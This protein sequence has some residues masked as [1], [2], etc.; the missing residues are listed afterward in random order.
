MFVVGLVIWLGA[1][2]VGPAGWAVRLRTALAGGFASAGARAEEKGLDLGPVGSW[3]AR[4]H[5]A[6]QIAG[7]V[8]AAAVL[9]FWGTPGIAGV[10]WTVVVL[11][12]YLAV[13]EFVGRL[14]R[15]AAGDAVASKGGQA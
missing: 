10:L 7:L 11:L 2:L 4:H 6:L 12:V 3:V 9:V 13:V 5:R 14:T 8:V 15:P 1:L